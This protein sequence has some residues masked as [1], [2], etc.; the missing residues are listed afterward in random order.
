[1]TSQ[2]EPA[3]LS[4]EA[5]AAYRS[6]FDSSPARF[7]VLEDFL[8]PALAE[9]LS[10]F[11]DSE[12]VYATE[13]GLYGVEDRRVEEQEWS[14][15]DEQKRFFRFSKIVG[16]QPE[17]QMSENA[18]AY[19]RFRSTFMRDAELRGFFEAVT[20]MSLGAS[21]DFGSHSMVAGDFLKAHDDDNRNRVLAL[22]LY[23]SPDWT[24]DYGGTLKIVDPA[25]EELTVEAK[26]NSLVAFDTRAGTSHYVVP[27][28]ERAGNRK[29][30]TIGGWYHEPP[31]S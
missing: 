29:R 18:L 11:L 19:L 8:K 26:Y 27:I 5:V 4:D 15:A 10:R 28:S 1:M 22:V 20:G 24:P 2:V 3:H 21:D 30:L 7:V 17:H 12:A 13:Y 9:R 31:A 14:A 25:G 16:I 6:R 23:L